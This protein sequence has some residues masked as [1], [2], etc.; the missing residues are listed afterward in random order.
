M[1]MP[2][3]AAA[4]DGDT[5]ED[6]AARLQDRMIASLVAIDKLRREVKTEQMNGTRLDVEPGA[7]SRAR[8]PLRRAAS[9]RGL[10]S[11]WPRPKPRGPERGRSPSPAVS[12]GLLDVSWTSSEGE[13]SDDSDDEEVPVGGSLRG[14]KAR[15]IMLDLQE[16]M[17]QAL[18]E[19]GLE[20]GGDALSDTESVDEDAAGDAGAPRRPGDAAESQGTANA[21]GAGTVAE[22][23][24]DLAVSPEHRA[25]GA[26]DSGLPQSPTPPAGAS[27]G[28]VAA[29][30][31]AS[32]TSPAELARR[33]AQSWSA[34]MRG[35]GPGLGGGGAGGWPPQRV[36]S[37]CEAEPGAAI[38]GQRAASARRMALAPCRSPVSGG[39]TAMSTCRSCSHAGPRS[40]G[41]DRCYG[42]HTV[43][44]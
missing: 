39:R 44:S 34:G 38:R 22:V 35:K 2:R 30:P 43:H 7:T 31:A 33:R 23:P 19:E 12:G 9:G 11:S 42:W 26:N 8:A 32:P 28:V 36:P 15:S 27:E 18:R 24:P 20:Y 13:S 25:E 21:S 5:D 16:E 6:A 37:H 1:D 3:E 17:R 10:G 4:D 41:H 40:A 29:S 14:L